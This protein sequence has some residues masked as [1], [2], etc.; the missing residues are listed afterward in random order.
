MF[1]WA[2]TIT[3]LTRPWFSIERM[4]R[5]YSMG[6]ETKT[7]YN[8][9]NAHNNFFVKPRNIPIQSSKAILN[10]SVSFLC[11]CSNLA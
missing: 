11:H 5:E 10:I 3:W 9:I 1:P 7:S 2:A 8:Q 4:F 6:K